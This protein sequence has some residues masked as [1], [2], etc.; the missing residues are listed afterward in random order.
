MKEEKYKLDRLD[1]IIAISLAVLCF[2]VLLTWC[3]SPLGQIEN[4]SLIGHILM[5]ASVAFLLISVFLYLQ[6][7]KRKKL[8]GLSGKNNK[9]TS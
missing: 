9:S 5:L 1:G 4:L 8:E 2:G 7:E 6:K 3:E